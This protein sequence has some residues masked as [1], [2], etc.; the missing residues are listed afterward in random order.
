MQRERPASGQ[1]NGSGAVG[2]TVIVDVEDAF[3]SGVIN[4]GI[5]VIAVIVA[6]AAGVFDFVGAGIIRIG[7]R[8]W[9]SL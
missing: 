4:V 7:F 2:E 5:P 6:R 9:C 3:G 1:V 8:L